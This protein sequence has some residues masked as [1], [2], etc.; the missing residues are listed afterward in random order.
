MIAVMGQSSAL[1]H[2]AR[3]GTAMPAQ[4]GR[5]RLRTCPGI[6]WGRRCASL[7]RKVTENSARPQKFST[8]MF[9]PGHII[10]V[11][12]SKYLPSVAAIEFPT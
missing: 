9:P 12:Q 1:G 3:N 7:R 6:G 11:N 5:D 10:A 8:A 4:S 2:P